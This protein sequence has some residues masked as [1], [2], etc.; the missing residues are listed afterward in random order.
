M[1][2]VLVLCDIVGRYGGTERYWETVLPRLAS[3]RT[4]RLAAR[5]VQESTRFGPAATQIPWGNEHDEPSAQAA[6]TVANLID[7]FEP[8][9][10][11]T[12][13][14][15]DPYVL[16]AVRAHARRWLARVHDYRPFCPNGNKVFPQFPAICHV[17]MG[18]P[19]R[20]NTLLRGCVCGPRSRSFRRIA[21]RLAVRDAIAQAD[22]V[23][24]SSDYVRATCVQNGI[25]EDRITITPPPLPDEAFAPE[26][27]ARPSERTMLFAGRMSEQ[28]G[29]RSL[30]TALSTIARDR[31]PVLVVAG[32]GADDEAHA[33]R[34]AA[35]SSVEIRWR[36]WMDA[37]ALR[38]AIDASL[39]VIVP[40]LWPEPFGLI[41]I[42]A[43]AR[44]RPAAAYEVGGVR[45]WIE[46]AGI[47][48]PR[49]DERALGRAIERLTWDEPLWWFYASAARMKA[50][51]H[52]L[53]RHLDR[54]RTLLDGVRMEAAQ[55]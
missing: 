12:A 25:R 21:N 35:Q 32:S 42:E 14:V 8:D 27:M 22:T 11:I 2:S 46:G 36:G 50:E 17:P 38:N 19:C 1:P 39:G 16:Q 6:R 47:P 24:V 41:G 37:A 48:V 44:G 9:A 4:V 49:A 33:R 54:L 13:N 29:L 43:Q 26:A 18:N 51:R 28:K 31:R 40:S 7:S 30:V 45:G 20:I 55:A 3:D 10:V 34:L 23:L 53:S 52:R 5:D 15:F